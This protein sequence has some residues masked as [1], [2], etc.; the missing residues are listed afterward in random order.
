MGRG[1]GQAAAQHDAAQLGCT[2]S[3]TLLAVLRSD[4]YLYG[5]LD[6]VHAQLWTRLMSRLEHTARR[7][8]IARAP[9]R[10]L[11]KKIDGGLNY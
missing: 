10:D 9:Q 11:H 8:P 5:H 7:A 6:L 4:N 3:Q 1:G 2:R